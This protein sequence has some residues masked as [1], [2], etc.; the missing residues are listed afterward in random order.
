LTF[1]SVDMMS[2]SSFYRPL[3]F[4]FPLYT[5]D[6]MREKLFRAIETVQI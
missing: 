4:S 2:F 3:S 1:L 5:P 6:R